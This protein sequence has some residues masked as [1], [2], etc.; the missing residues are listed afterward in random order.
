[1]K[2]QYNR[3]D[4]AEAL[5]QMYHSGNPDQIRQAWHLLAALDD[6]VLVDF[7][8]G[9]H[10]ILYKMIGVTDVSMLKHATRLRMLSL[11]G[12]DVAV[13]PDLRRTS[14]NFADLFESK[15]TDLS[16]L[17][18]CKRLEKIHLGWQPGLSL[19]ALPKIPSLRWVVVIGHKGDDIEVI[20]EMPW[21]D[22]L[23]LGYC[24][25]LTEEQLFRIARMPNLLRLQCIGLKHLSEEARLAAADIVDTR[26]LRVAA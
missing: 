18:G 26:R 22:R 9:E 2:A 25:A 20:A 5:Y 13:L 12:T 6:P 16:P 4:A 14:I 21:L 24:P 23:H 8:I 15:V 7:L 1:M 17:I 19:A 11:I 3:E 10:V